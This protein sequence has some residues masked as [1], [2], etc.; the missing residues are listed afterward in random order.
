[1]QAAD[2]AAQATL[3]R[4][5]WA[6]GERFGDAPA[7]EDGPTTLSFVGLADAGLRAAR[8]LTAAGM[9]P[10][11]R[12]AL[13]APNRWEWIVAALG[14]QL[15]GGAIVT[16]NTRYK[17]PEAAYQIEKCRTR[18]AFT[19]GEF[20]GFR[21][22][23][24]LRK[25]SLPSLEH[26]V[27]FDGEAEGATG[28]AEFLAR[29]ESTSEDAARARA[30][31]VAPGDVADVI[32]TSGTTG[33]PKGVMASHAQNLKTMEVWSRVIGLREGDRYLIVNP[34]FHTFG[35]KAGWLACLM[36]GATALPV[37]AFDVDV[38]LRRIADERISV[39]PGTPT[40]YQSLLAHPDL[41]RHDVSSLRMASTGG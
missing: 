32:F 13:W 8:A 23:D 1:M 38:A 9:E 35:Y 11:E 33:R 28:F 14:V 3:P 41:A 16:L 15:A 18:F 31:A 27:L 2:P 30:E 37:A 36:R 5:L 29:A 10:G 22:A 19:V 4:L 39:L 6:A 7:V 12:V 21:Y 26:V 25:E 17:G 24:A 40:L 34:F 20:L